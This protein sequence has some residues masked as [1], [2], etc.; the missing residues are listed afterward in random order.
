MGLPLSRQ[1]S[2][3]SDNQK[4]MAGQIEERWT[5][6]YKRREAELNKNQKTAN[7]REIDLMNREYDKAVFSN[8]ISK[9]SSPLLFQKS[10]NEL[11]QKIKQARKNIVIIDIN[12]PNISSIK[13]SDCGHFSFISE[14][15]YL[16]IY[17]TVIADRPI[18]TI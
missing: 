3:E 5:H 2:L 11:I 9:A 14:H 16:H 15:H 13:M 12:L 18:H 6:I 10:F 7:Q 17:D 4:R 1:I 8:I